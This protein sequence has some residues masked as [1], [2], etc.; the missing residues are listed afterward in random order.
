MQLR[1]SKAL[2]LLLSAINLGIQID[3]VGLQMHSGMHDI[4]AWAIVGV[5]IEVTFSIYT[6]I[7]ALWYMCSHQ[8]P[9]HRSLTLHMF[10]ILACAFIHR[11]LKTIGNFLAIAYIAPQLHWTDYSLLAISGLICIVVAVIPL[12]PKLHQDMTKLYNKSITQKLQELGLGS[13]HN[14]EPNVNEEVSSSILGRLMLSFVYP[15]ISKVSNME[16]ADVQDLPVSLA[17]FRTQH[18]LH[19]SVLVN[20]NSGIHASWAPTMAFLWTMWWPERKAVL[21][22]GSC[23]SQL[24][25]RSVL[26]SIKF[27]PTF[28]SFAHSGSY[29]ISACNRSYMFL[30]ISMAAIALQ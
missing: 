15:M 30:T 20:D 4:S 5:V 23:S 10:A 16:Q 6:F 19:Q 1:V 11:Y 21:E 22:R 24:C 3:D 7:L 27:L 2:V 29:H 18:I 14:T 17:Y 8:V 12:G 25:R 13:K 9:R 26:T 28:L